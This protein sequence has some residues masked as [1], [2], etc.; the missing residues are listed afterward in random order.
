MFL[1]AL[2]EIKGKWLENDSHCGCNQGKPGLGQ[3][4]W[5]VQCSQKPG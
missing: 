3:I 5:P 4:F 2:H 1:S